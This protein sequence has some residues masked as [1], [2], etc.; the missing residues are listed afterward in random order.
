MGSSIRYTTSKAG[1]GALTKKKKKEKEKVGPG[2]VAGRRAC[3]L[4]SILI[5]RLELD[6]VRANEIQTVRVMETGAVDQM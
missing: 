3:R 1:W 6:G 4:Y 5:Y 2:G